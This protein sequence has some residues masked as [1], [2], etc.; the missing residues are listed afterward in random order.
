MLLSAGTAWQVFL[1]ARRWFD[2]LTG[3]IAVLFI[4]V[5]PLYSLGA[6]LMTIDPLSAFFWIWAANFFTT[7]WET[8]RKWDWAMAGFAIGAGFLAKYLNGLEIVAFLAFSLVPRPSRSVGVR[9]APKGM[10]ALFGLMFV[11]GVI[12]ILPVLWWNSQN[13]WPTIH[14]LLTRV[15]TQNWKWYQIDLGLELDYFEKQALVVVSP[16]LFLLFMYEGWVGFK[17]W[18][19]AGRTTGMMEGGRL[20]HGLFLSVFLFYF[21]VA[22]H[23]VCEPNWPA[24]SYLSLSI[25]LAARARGWLAVPGFTLAKTVLTCAYLL[26]MVETVALH[27]TRL[28]Q[29]P[30]KLDAFSR[31]SGWQELAGEV[32]KWRVQLGNPEMLA[33]AYKEAAVVSFHLPDQKMVYSL[34]GAEPA[35]QF[36]MW[37]GIPGSRALYF[38]ESPTAERVQGKYKK[39]RQ[40]EHF[41]LSYRD[42]KLRSYY[43]YLI[44]E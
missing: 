1:L 24:I 21:I 15:D 28:M 38:T 3:V 13:G 43:L 5:I 42:T 16:L 18:A 6:V 10:W 20:M 34:R 11:V 14:H 19:G 40:L 7:G 33:D 35:S 12:S 17:Y 41:Q 32:Q 39:I 27:S 9:V 8:G 30:V 44:E 4:S 25:A 26:A 31:T 36:D 23:H 29:I 2:E 37:P 22:F